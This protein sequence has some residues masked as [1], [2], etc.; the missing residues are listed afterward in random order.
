MYRIIFLLEAVVDIESAD[1]WYEDKQTN[2]GNRFKENTLA[3]IDKLQSDKIVYKSLY[4]GLSRVFVKR[5]PYIVYFK[6][7]KERKEII[8]FGVLHM[9]QSKSN[10]DKRI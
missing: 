6:K 2:L 10:L 7:E 3:A 5:F 8:V 9:K 1:R 4:R